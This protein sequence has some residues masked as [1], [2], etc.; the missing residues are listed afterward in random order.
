MDGSAD[1]FSVAGNVPSQSGVIGSGTSLH[2]TPLVPHLRGGGGG[3][4]SLTSR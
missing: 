1:T 2:F 3:G 4:P